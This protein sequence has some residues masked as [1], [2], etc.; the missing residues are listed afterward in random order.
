MVLAA[1]NLDISFCARGK[2]LFQLFPSLDPTRVGVSGTESAIMLAFMW[3]DVVV[4]IR[5]CL[6]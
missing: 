1:K 3:P 5:V 4:N 2:T 6:V